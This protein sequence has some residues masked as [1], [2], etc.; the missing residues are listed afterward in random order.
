[1]N[2]GL[3]LDEEIVRK[4]AE[5]AKGM[6]CPACGGSIVFHKEAEQDYHYSCH[7]FPRCNTTTRAHKTG[8]PMGKPADSSTRYLRGQ[9][10]QIFDKLWES[11]TG[12]YDKKDIRKW[13]YTWISDKMG[14]REL[15]FGNLNNQAL[16]QAIEILKKATTL[17]IIKA[18]EEQDAR[19]LRIARVKKPPVLVP[20]IKRIGPP[21]VAQ[22]YD[23]A[24]Y[25]RT[26]FIRLLK[27][28]D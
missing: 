15:H 26:G 18:K 16:Q 13:C 19:N 17:D 6:I 25:I 7:A 8:E 21:P 23:K 28:P 14:M 2:M 10:H 4:G 3:L 27:K 20:L 11:Y 5:I 9:A 1:M 22:P 24:H 12:R